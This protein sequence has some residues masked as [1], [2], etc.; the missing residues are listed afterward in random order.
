MILFDLQ[1]GI[2]HQTKIGYMSPEI[3][4]THVLHGN[5]IEIYI[6]VYRLWETISILGFLVYR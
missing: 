4:N 1:I 6:T 5:N 2:T 3:T